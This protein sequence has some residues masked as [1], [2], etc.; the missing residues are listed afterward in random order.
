M[1]AGFSSCLSLSLSLSSPFFPPF[2]LSFFCLL[3]LHQDAIIQDISQE[4]L[5]A[6]NVEEGP[7][8]LAESSDAGAHT[9]ACTHA[10]LDYK[11]T[12]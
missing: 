11:S 2:F 3:C 5:K 12:I 9:H 8:V 1:E 10:H 6:L 7:R 4:E